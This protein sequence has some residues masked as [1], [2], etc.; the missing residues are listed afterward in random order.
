[1]CGTRCSNILPTRRIRT[2]KGYVG[3]SGILVLIQYVLN[4]PL[5]LFV[6]MDRGRSRISGKGVHMYKSVRVRFAAFI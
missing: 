3:T 5:N 4:L 2:N 1:M 6:L